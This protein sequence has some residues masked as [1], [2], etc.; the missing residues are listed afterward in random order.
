MRH[1]AVRC[2]AVLMLG[3]FVAAAP[4]KATPVDFASATNLVF[5]GAAGGTQLSFGNST[6]T[7]AGSLFGAVVSITPT[8]VFS[9]GSATAIAGATSAYLLNGSGT[10]KIFLDASNFL[11]ATINLLNIAQFSGIGG[12]NINADANLSGIAV[13]GSNPLLTQFLGPPPGGAV[14]TSFQFSGIPGGLTAVAGLATAATAT[15]SFSGTATPV[16]EPGSMILFGS[17]LLGLA[18]AVRR[19]L[20]I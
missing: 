1:A 6:V 13:A 19:R 15:T 17:G 7:D 3:T 10:F 12:T 2:L 11:T 18:A 20:K 9:I 4:A 16:P 5:T 8:G 14:T